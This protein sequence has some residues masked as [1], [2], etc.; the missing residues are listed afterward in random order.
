[1]EASIRARIP[2]SKRNTP[3]ARRLIDFLVS[4]YRVFGDLDPS[5]CTKTVEFELI[6]RPS[7]VSF[8]AGSKKGPIDAY[9]PLKD[10][11]DRKLAIQVPWDEPAYGFVFLVPKGNDKWRVTIS[12]AEV[13]R[14]T[15]RVDP[16]GGFMPASMVMEA[17]RV[18]FCPLVAQLDM[19]D[20]FLTLR[21]DEEAQRLSTFATPYGKVRWLHGWFGWHS[22]PA[23]FQQLMMESVVLPTLQDVPSSQILAWIDDV[24][25]GARDESAFLR[26]L[27]GVV[28]RILSFGGRLSLGKCNFLPDEIDWCGVEVNVKRNEWR[29][30][31]GRVESLRRL[32]IPTTHDDLIHTLG[33]LRYYYFGVVDQKAQR[34]R[35]AKLAALDVPGKPISGWTDEHTRALRE[36]CEAIASG[37]WILVFD[38]LQPVYL[39][40]DASGEHG[41]CITALQ[42]DAEGAPRPVLFYSRGWL[43]TQTA[44]TAQTKETYALLRAVYY[45]APDYF[46]GARLI[47]VTDNRNLASKAQSEDPRIRQWKEQIEATGADVRWIPGILNSIADHGSRAT[48]AEPEATL[49]PLEKAL[50]RVYY[51]GLLRGDVPAVEIV[52]GGSPNDPFT[53]WQPQLSP[54]FTEKLGVG[55]ESVPVTPA[56]LGALAG[57][58]R[59]VISFMR[60]RDRAHLAVL[61]A[62]EARDLRAANR[63]KA[64]EAA[65]GAGAAAASASAKP[66][67]EATPPPSSSCTDLVLVDTIDTE[68]LEKAH[69]PR[70]GRAARS[71]DDLPDSLLSTVVP[72]HMLADPRLLAIADAQAAA[73]PQEVQRWRSHRG[74][75][76]SI[77]F[78]ED[79]QLHTIRGRVI[80]PAG[81]HDLRR[82]LLE[83]AHDHRL[84][85]SAINRTVQYL[86]R[87]MHV[88]WYGLRESVVDYISSCVHCAFGKPK[89]DRER[90]SFGLSK[91]TLAPGVGHTWYADFKGPIG[92]HYLLVVV[93]AISRMVRL[94]SVKSTKAVDV[95]PAFEAVITSFDHHHP[96]VIRTD[97]GPPFNSEAFNL[98]CKDKGIK[99]VLGHP[100]HHQGQGAV[101][102]VMRPISDALI[103]TYGNNATKYFRDPATLQRLEQI[104]NTTVVEPVFGSPVEIYYGRPPRTPETLSPAAWGDFLGSCGLDASSYTQIIAYHHDAIDRRQQRA[105]LASSISQQLGAATYNKSRSPPSFKIGDP[106]L[107]FV[108]PRPTRVSV[109]FHGPY[110]TSKVSP[111]GHLVWG[112]FFSSPEGLYTGP[113]HVS[114]IVPFNSSRFDPVTASFMNIKDGQGLVEKVL[115]HRAVPGGGY[116]FRI[117]WFGT[118]LESWTTL[119]GSGRDS[120]ILD[121]CREKGLE[122]EVRTRKGGRA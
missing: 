54:R 4:R 45:F 64:S 108:F 93:E 71:L 86:E 96:Y 51:M 82:E 50:A 68:D 34:A 88:T 19:K 84:H 11:L 107:V 119:E 18:G 97:G 111:D 37:D 122:V 65:A 66:A 80:I 85:F 2:E 87:G 5:E 53:T 90:S 16:A 7:P 109:Y 47:L 14:V 77:P 112:R 105:L 30:A 48:R 59:S 52:T 120:G 35:I 9:A 46:P 83:L 72:G 62:R 75:Y 6:G 8:R 36:A 38:P 117:K 56:L 29:I 76:Q 61:S 15:K 22:F 58:E 104:I 27:E 25:V 55:K 13:N 81:A 40:T 1:M 57:A 41:Y 42:Y 44:W 110:I 31:Q 26:A 63:A 115:E 60:A 92:G 28:D 3:L 95:I 121:Y 23:V 98:F 101:E 100:G 49:S 106:F 103:S 74:D 12:P 113:F 33:I 91:P 102:T 17:H 89:G 10:W 43:S 21:L 39:S 94:R 67:M 78:L 118:T 70:L 69:L 73:P 24:V 99:L 32:P 79:K 20:A 114:R 116:E